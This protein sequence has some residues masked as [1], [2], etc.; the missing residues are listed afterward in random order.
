[1][2]YALRAGIGATALRAS[3]LNEAEPLPP[4][5][6]EIVPVPEISKALK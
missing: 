2:K 5:L 1:M 6:L 3:V 4:P